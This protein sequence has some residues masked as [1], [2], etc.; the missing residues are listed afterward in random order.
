MAYKLPQLSKHTIHAALGHSVAHKL[1][2]LAK[3]SAQRCG[4]CLRSPVC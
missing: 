3:H 2:Q 1:A 4:V